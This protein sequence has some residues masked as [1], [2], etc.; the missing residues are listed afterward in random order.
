[1]GE[2]EDPGEDSSLLPLGIDHVLIKRFS[3]NTLGKQKSEMQGCLV[4][5]YSIPK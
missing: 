1:M 4:L 2:P 5:Q 3:R